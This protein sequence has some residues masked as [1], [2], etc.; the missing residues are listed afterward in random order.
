MEAKKVSEPKQGESNDKDPD[1][2]D[3]LN[4]DIPG[5]QIDIGELNVIEGEEGEGEEAEAGVWGDQADTEIM[6]YTDLY[7]KDIKVGDIFLILFFIDYENFDNEIHDV[8]CEIENINEEDHIITISGT[9]LLIK[10]LNVTDDLNIILTTEDYKILDIEKINVIEEKELEDLEL[11]LTKQLIKEIVFEDILTEDKNYTDNEKKEEL[12]SELINLLNAYNNERLLKEIT[13]IC[14]YFLI[15]IREKLNNNLN[16]RDLLTFVHEI[17]NNNKL[18]IPKYIK[19]IVSSKRN[20]Y[21]IAYPDQ[22]ISEDINLLSFKD[23]IE[24]LYKSLET[25]EVKNMN[26]TDHLNIVLN[27][28][29]TNYQLNEKDKKLITEYEGEYL[30]D[31]LFEETCIGALIIN[32]EDG[33]SISILQNNY[34]YDDVRTRNKLFLPVLKS[35]K[36]EFEVIKNKEKINLVG[37]LLFPTNFLYNLF[38]IKL[39]SKLFTLN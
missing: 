2:P 11:K 6:L 19:P 7:T 31:C 4:P 8:I 9:D 5:D 37:L 15:L 12:L 18:D 23:E 27:N 32:D 24:E 13:D 38:N 16:N 28:N 29:Y 3:E 30:R 17:I 25:Q 22:E 33:N 21:A 36:I 14:E 20:I 39:D 10:T 34:S 35:D 26:Y 1:I